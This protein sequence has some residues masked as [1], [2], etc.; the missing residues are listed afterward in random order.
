MSNKY[1]IIY[2]VFEEII[3]IIF[4]K[5]KGLSLI[6][7]KRISNFTGVKKCLTNND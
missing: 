2:E 1:L 7:F 5:L 6:N 4:E 3:L